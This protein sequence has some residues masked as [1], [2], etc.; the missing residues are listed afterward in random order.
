[1]T[2]RIILGVLMTPERKVCVRAARRLTAPAERTCDRVRQGEGVW[3]CVS[4]SVSA[5]VRMCEPVCRR[6]R[7]E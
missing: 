7:H 4:T 5:H 2:F 6:V 1:M 3:H